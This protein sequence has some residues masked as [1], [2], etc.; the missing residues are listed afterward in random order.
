MGL[1]GW[2]AG[3]I[4]ILSFLVLPA[5]GTAA[6]LTYL[7]SLGKYSE[8]RRAAE[9]EIASKREPTTAH[10]AHLC[11]ALSRLKIY[12]ALSGCLSN[13]EARIGRGEWQ[14]PADFPMT[15]RADARPLPHVLR[16]EMLIDFGDYPG[17]IAEATLGLK[18]LP[19]DSSGAELWPRVKYEIHL[20]SNLALATSYAGDPA[21]AARHLK[22]LEELRIGWGGGSWG[23]IKANGL[24]RGYMA[25]GD[26]TKSLSFIASDP[27]A[28]GR[29]LV[30]LL[31]GLSLRGDSV[32]KFTQIPRALMLAR[33]L[34]E[35][36]KVAE[37]RDLLDKLLAEQLLA[38]QAD[39]LWLTLHER[40]QIAETENQPVEA[41]KLYFRAIEV[42]EQQRSSINTEASR[43][44]FVGD[45][46]SVYG[47]TIGLLVRANRASEAFDY[48]ERSKSR[49]LVD[50]LAAKKDFS[51][52]AADQARSQRLLFQLD[53]AD[54][55]ARVQDESVPAREN[56]SFRDR[57]AAITDIRSAAPELSTL[58]TVTSVPSD[59]LRALVGTDDALIEY[60]YYGKE[61]HA[62][63]LTRERVVALTLQSEGLADDVNRLRRGIEDVGSNKWEAPA[64]ALYERLWKP[65]ADLVGN[66]NRIIVPHGVLHY[67][68]F[69]ALRKADGGL[70]VEE[71]ALRFLP[72]ASVLKFL[73]PG[74]GVKPGQLLVLGN[75]DLGD[76][77]M[78]LKFAEGEARTVAA[79]NPDSR[80]LLRK[81][82]SETNFKKAGM[83]FS[84]I[85]FASHGKFQADDPLRSGLFLA[86]DNEN[87]GMLTV[88]ELYSM[89]LDADLVTL[90]ACETGLGKVANGDDVVG[91]TRGFLYAGSRSIVASLWSVDDKA[92]AELMQTF[93]RNLGSMPKP[94]ALRL[95]QIQTRKGFASPFFW[96]AFQI[97][98]RAD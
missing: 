25:L 11:V 53:A 46:Q 69:S 7:E 58:V 80:I 34:K 23:P 27:Y 64:S 89:S 97:T 50:M 8:L 90:S 96:A 83:L 24:A 37:A 21:G 39:V 33:C 15:P 85:H 22:S 79:I 26:C 74:T 47:R 68:P 10:L 55:A 73:R 12:S 16:S 75:P 40:G 66:R 5:R 61:L 32:G 67:L 92:T 51:M 29:G 2:I 17:A 52:Q 71:S 41:L 31:A 54:L 18:K 60:Y 59:E 42:I 81:E 76:P 94:E 65:L 9:Q 36:G 43:I 48:A 93:Y 56:A 35:T 20:L 82:A 78:D 72:S 62:F 95:A 84:R 86:K 3:L 6:S 44:G 88:G 30:D 28:L 91:L 4:L 45:K 98:G 49:S 19:S 77:R 38:D 1:T 70:L 14:W 63:V 13:L 87:D 57:R